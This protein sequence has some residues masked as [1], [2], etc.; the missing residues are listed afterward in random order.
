MIKYYEK[1]QLFKIDTPDSS[2]VMAVA[3]GFLGHVY[4]GKRLSDY[5]IGYL[6][7]TEDSP[8]VPSVN[9]RDRVSFLDAFPMEYS[10][11]GTGDFRETCMDVINGNGQKNTELIYDSHVIYKGKKALEGLPSTWG[12]DCDSLDIVL[13][14]AANDLEVTLTYSAFEGIDAVIKSVKV[15]NCGAHPVTLEKVMSTSIDVEDTGFEIMTMHGSWAREN[16]IQRRDVGYGTCFVD[17]RRGIS[18]HQ[19]HP[20]MALVGKNADQ[21]QGE[22]YAYNFIYS[23]SFICSAEKSQFAHIRMVMGI[24]PADFSW[25]LEP[26][27][28]FQAPEA[29]V[30]YSSEGIGCMTRTL[31]DLYRK[32]LIRSVWKDRE[33]PVLINNWEAT[34]FDFNIDKLLQIVKEAAANKIEMFVLDDGWFGHRDSDNS[35]LGDWFVDKRK[36]PDGLEK[37]SEEVKKSGMKFGLW[38]EPEM[39][40]EDSELYKAHPDWVIATEGKEPALAREQLVLDFS[41]QEVV[42]YLFDRMSEIIETAKLDYIKWD[43]NRPLTDLGSKM[44]PANR[45]GELMHRYMLGVYSLQERITSAFPELFLEN[46]SSGGGRFDAGM[47]YYSPQIWCS[48]DTDAIERLVIQEGTLMLYPSSAM[49]AHVSICPNHTT[50]RTVPFATRANVAEAGTFGYELDITKLDDEEKAQI[51]KQIEN[52]KKYYEV[53]AY[54]DYYRLAS[55]RENG[56]YDAYMMVSKDKKKAYLTYVQ[57]QAVPNSKRRR[58][59]LDG[60]DAEKRYRIGDML[61]AGDTLMYAGLLMPDLYG[62]AASVILEIT[63]EV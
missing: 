23:G 11:G 58:I 26:G 15:K 45:Q 52:H 54:G 1:E 57:V 46:C 20:F 12:E 42:D 39:I 17:S 34:Y 28:T 55:Y 29:V 21:K 37:L 6:L 41:R 50:G 24:H 40:S 59:K 38:F 48:D 60:L 25:T 13:K 33:R 4:Y 7:R 47:L 35:S 31:H 9:R 53:T 5:N 16:H 63:E 51:P 19:N 8:F 27:D 22:V 36:L 14:D 62:D 18:S 43:M 3:D 44:L 32:H 10:F 49:G 56:K 2:Y 61:Y 30:V